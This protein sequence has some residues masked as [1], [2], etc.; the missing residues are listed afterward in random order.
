[1]S[2]TTPAPATYRVINGI[3]FVVDDNYVGRIGALG[4]GIA[5]ALP[6]M[7]PVFGFPH[8]TGPYEIGTLTYHWVDASRSEVF[9]ADPKERRQLMVQIWY[10]AKANQ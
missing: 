8:P 7:V 3:Q 2:A 10:P 9:A 5:V 1:M 6:M 4:L